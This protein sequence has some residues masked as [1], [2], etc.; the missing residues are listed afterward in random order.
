[1]NTR[2]VQD[3]V[4]K[5]KEVFVGLEDSKKTWKLAVRCEDKM[6]IH[7]ASMEAKYRYPHPVP[8]DTSSP[9]ARSTSSTRRASRASTSLT[10]L[11]EDGI[12]CVVIPPHLV[13]EPKTQRVKT[14]KIDAS[15]L[16]YVLETTTS[17]TAAMFPT[18]RGERT[19]R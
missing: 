14:D 2:K 8:Q 6:I 16:A 7:R 13:T 15:R 1:M 4:V 9:N 5:G 12:D 10:E 11:T 18:R 19:G 17:R 3:F